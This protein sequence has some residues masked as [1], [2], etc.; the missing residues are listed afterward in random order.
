MAVQYVP[1][2]PEKKMQ[3]LP[4]N[5]EINMTI[6]APMAATQHVEFKTSAV[7]RAKGFLLASVPLY[8]AFALCVVAVV[9]LGWSVPLL[10]L[11]TLVIFMLSFTAAW[12]VGYGYTLSVSAEGISLYESV[13]K[14]SVIKEEQRRRWEAWERGNDDDNR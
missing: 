13:S 14:W 3:P 9:V 8:M 7:D 1:A 5:T 11:P 6:D 10:S 4:I 12:V 2:I